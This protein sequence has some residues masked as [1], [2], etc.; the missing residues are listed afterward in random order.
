MLGRAAF[1]RTLTSGC[2]QERRDKV[3]CGVVSRT[4]ERAWTTMAGARR[5]DS[6]Q[7]PALLGETVTAATNDCPGAAAIVDQ[8]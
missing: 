8:A 4:L 5:D 3:A 1:G 6:L 7:V 2:H